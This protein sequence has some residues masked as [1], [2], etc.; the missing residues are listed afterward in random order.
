MHGV[1]R[2]PAMDLSASKTHL[3]KESIRLAFNDLGAFHY[4]RGDLNTS[5]K[6]GAPLR[7]VVFCC[8][9][10]AVLPHRGPPPARNQPPLH[11]SVF[12][13]EYS[14]GGLIWGGRFFGFLLKFT[15]KTILQDTP[16]AY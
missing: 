4:D 3:I 8:A 12:F 6:A 16:K 9:C 14:K 5:L 1:T 10:I 13:P 15:K 2:C 7:M 11:F